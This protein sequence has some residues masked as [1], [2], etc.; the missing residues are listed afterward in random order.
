M[1]RK[2]V[3]VPRTPTEE[4][5]ASIW[6]EMLGIE[7]VGP[8]DNFFELGGHSLLA[9]RL[10]SRLSEAFE[11][12]L[13]LR[14]LFE[15]PTVAD[16]SMR[17]ERSMRSGWS[18]SLPPIV[19]V[20]RSGALPLSFAQQRL[21]LADQIEPGSSAYNVSSAVRIVGPLDFSALARSFVALSER[22]EML[23]TTFGATAGVPY[24]E[25]G[26]AV[27]RALPVFDLRG[28]GEAGRLG[29]SLRLL[30]AAARVSF[31]LRRGPL[32]RASI[33]RR[34]D[35]ENLLSL[36]LHH[37]A[38]D[39]WSTGIFIRESRAFYRAFVGGSGSAGCSRVKPWR[40]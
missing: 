37:I 5:V 40:L 16:L 25:I 29:E 12:E 34:T 2:M 4:V 11:V 27:A 9:T 1:L 6:S 35:D 38:A 15:A 17:L 20:P 39:A 30:A 19:A 28:L 23:R 14:D 26:P 7:R 24:Q 22:H 21:W 36:T 10:A 18:L 3:G 13:P 31:D 32:W 8:E 33:V